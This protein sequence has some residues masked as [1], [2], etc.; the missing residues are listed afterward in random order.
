MRKGR[1]ERIV[2]FVFCFLEW[3]GMGL[4]RAV[5]DSEQPLSFPTCRRPTDILHLNTIDRMIPISFAHCRPAKQ[6][7][8]ALLPSG[9]YLGLAPAASLSQLNT[10]SLL[11][12]LIEKGVVDTPLWAL[13]LLNG[14][15]GLFSL[16]GTPLASIRKVEKETQDLL[17]SQN[18]QEH[19]ELKR[20]EKLE[21][22]VGVY[23]S[24]V[25]RDPDH[26][27]KWM[28]V[29]GIGGF[30]QIMMHGVW[31]D[32]VENVLN[33]PAVLDV[34]LP[35]P[36]PSPSILP[37]HKAQLNTPFILAPPMATRTL[38]AQ[39][40]SHRLP[41]PYDQ[42]H[43]YPCLKPPQL[44]LDFAGW[45]AEVLKGR[46]KEFFSAPGGRF[47]LGRLE[48]G[49]GYCVG[50]VVESRMGAHRKEGSEHRHGGNEGKVG[51]LGDVWVLGEPVFRDVQVAFDVSSWGV[52]GDGVLIFG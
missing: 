40:Q 10:T 18:P 45:Q 7:I 32:G 35:L 50:M 49:S 39:T 43:A 51:G 17:S 37:T 22:R 27:W 9:A 8:Q 21:E 3:D 1:V 4:M 11:P 28:D 46:N 13:V 41:P 26:E 12:Q 2:S 34:Y 44:H 33:Q 23:D 47:S 29:R 42:F 36:S 24:E 16:G 31:V 5:E 48:E 6:W 19:E 52:I 15:D 14:Q 20:E 38:Y 25:A 30:W